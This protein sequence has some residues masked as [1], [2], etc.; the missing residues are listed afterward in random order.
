MVG[1]LHSLINGLE[2]LPSLLFLKIIISSDRL[3]SPSPSLAPPSWVVLSRPS[4]TGSDVGSER[5][6]WRRR[7]GV[8]LRFRFLLFLTFEGENQTS[9][10]PILF[11]DKNNSWLLPPNGLNFHLIGGELQRSACPALCPFPIPWPHLMFTPDVLSRPLTPVLEE[12][13]AWTDCCQAEAP[14][15]PLP[16]TEAPA[17]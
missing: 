2:P 9:I 12:G 5:G 3:P 16:L 10:L 14:P 17:S 1:R 11:R 4:L 6:H 13:V 8:L 15:P 7:S